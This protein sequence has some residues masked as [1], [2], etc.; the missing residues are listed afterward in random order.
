MDHMEVIPTWRS[1]AVPVMGT[2]CC[3][4]HSI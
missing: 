2:C 4:T 3:M 1:P